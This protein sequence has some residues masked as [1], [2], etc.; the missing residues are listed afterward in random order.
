[1]KGPQ[2]FDSIVQVKLFLVAVFETR[3]SPLAPENRDDLFEAEPQAL[4]QRGDELAD[5]VVHYVAESRCRRR[6]APDAPDFAEQIFLRT[7]LISLDSGGAQ[8]QWFE[9]RRAVA[10]R[11]SRDQRIDPWLCVR[12]KQRFGNGG[13]AC[14]FRRRRNRRGLL[15]ILLRNMRRAQN[16]FKENGGPRA[17]VRDRRQ[18]QPLARSGDGHVKQTALLLNMEVASRQF[19]FHQRFRKLEHRGARR[20]RKS[21]M[22]QP[23]NKHVLE[24]Q[25]LRRMHG[26]QLDRVARILLQIDLPA[27]LHE[28]IEIFDKFRQ[29]RSFALGLPFANKLRQPP[30]VGPIGGTNAERKFQPFFERFE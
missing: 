29:A 27:G 6:T 23:Q 28:V 22:S 3:R 20:H 2:L 12:K 8:L 9:N 19:L 30:D 15:H 21:A 13:H 5:R 17:L 24:F 11:P 4:A 26:H 7:F 10:L 16:V 1:M 25:P 14:R 18:S